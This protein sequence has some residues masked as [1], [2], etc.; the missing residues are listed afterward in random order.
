MMSNRKAGEDRAIRR[1]QR[2]LE[3]KQEKSAQAVK[4]FK[5]KEAHKNMLAAELR[6]LQEEDMQKVHERAKRLATRKKMEIMGKEQKDLETVNEVKRR[7]QKLIDYR[8]RNM[9]ARNIGNEEFTENL[10]NWAKMG[11]KG[12]FG[13]DGQELLGMIEK[14]KASHTRNLY[15]RVNGEEV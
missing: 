4:D 3:E 10:D 8:Y 1:R 12:S 2:E 9:V 7:E 13:K 5:D 11:Y 15:S 14:R 6:K